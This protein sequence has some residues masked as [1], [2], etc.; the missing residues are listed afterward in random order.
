[1]LHYIHAHLHTCSNRA[2]QAAQQRFATVFFWACFQVKYYTIADGY[3][4]NHIS[5]FAVTYLEHMLS[6]L[7]TLGCFHSTSLLTAYSLS[8]LD[9]NTGHFENNHLIVITGQ[10]L[11]EAK[12]N[13]Q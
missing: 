2:T 12:A 1:M 3:T 6:L 7:I 11:M 5:T 9:R 4:G 13:T 10:Y 8:I